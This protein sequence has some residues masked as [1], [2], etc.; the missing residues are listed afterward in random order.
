MILQ[1]FWV[2][3]K[4]GI[5]SLGGGYVFYPLVEQEVVE[6]YGW[7]TV[8]EFV[9]IT[10]ITQVVPGAISVK[11]AAYV[12]Y[13]V[14]GIVGSAAAILGVIL[15]PAVIII[16]LLT[17]LVRYQ[18]HPLFESLLT[19]VRFATVGLVL[20][21]AYEVLSSVGIEAR[22]VLLSAGVFVALLLNIPPAVMIILGGLMG[23]IVF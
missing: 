11:Y 6:N 7:L 10:G 20:Y 23:I 8:E 3:F 21:F 15:P 18:Q 17:L 12:G 2:F 14:A 16:L 13:R 5:L 1:L 19:G 22:G 4:I 9:E